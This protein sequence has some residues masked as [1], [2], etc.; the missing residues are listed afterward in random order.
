MRAM[1]RA[2]LAFAAVVLIGYQGCAGHAAYR[3]VADGLRAPGWRW[4]P[5]NVARAISA[6]GTD[7]EDT[8]RYLAYCDAILGRPRSTFYVR[9]PG[10]PA[11]VGDPDA[12]PIVAGPPL[13]P[14]RDFQVEYPPGFFLVTLPAALLTA[15]PDAFRRLFGL[16]MGACLVGALLMGGAIARR[17]GEAPTRLGWVCTAAVLALG[18]IVVRRYDAAVALALTTAVF[19]TTAR[20][21]ILA[22]IALGLAIALKGTP[23]VAAPIFWW[24]AGPDRRRLAL[25]ALAPLVVLCAPFAAGLLEVA[26]YHAARP[27]QIESTLGALAAWIDPGQAAVRSFGST[28]PAGAAAAALGRIAL[29]LAALAVGGALWR[30]RR[31][32]PACGVVLVLVALMVS[33]KVFSPQYL[34]WLLPLAPLAAGRRAFTFVALCLLTQIIYPISYPALSAQAGWAC[35]LVLTRNLGLGALALRLDPA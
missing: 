1:R 18:V 33:G 14:Y 23:I 4:T 17:R 28:N 9:A 2:A 12:A 5:A 22:G 30:A 20:R 19:A 6:Y 29:P 8:R 32:E 15:D 13:R 26:R 7:D 31:W 21:P 34:V 3:A 16:G 27:L 11:P 35:A 25:A 24:H 10:A